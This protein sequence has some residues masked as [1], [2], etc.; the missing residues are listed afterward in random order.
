MKHKKYIISGA[1]LICSSLTLLFMYLP[2]Q[3]VLGIFLF[4]W[5]N[6]IERKY[7]DED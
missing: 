7:T 2:W 6:N 3:A 1:I 4:T 5:A